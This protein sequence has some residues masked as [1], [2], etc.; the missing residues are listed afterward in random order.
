MPSL[1]RAIV[2]SA[3]A[4]VTL[5]L[6]AQVARAAA[7][8][9]QRVPQE[10]ALAREATGPAVVELRWSDVVRLS[11]RHPRLVA[12][13]L[14]TE[15]VR[16]GVAVAQSWPNPVLDA[17]LGRSVARPDGTAGAEWE[18]ALTLPLTPLV[19]RGARRGVALAESEV[20]TAEASVLRRELLGELRQS[21]LLLAHQQEQ[22]ATLE[23]L[24]EELASLAA[25]TQKKVDAG[26]S[27]P[28]EALR[29]ELA[30]QRLLV[31]L[32]GARAEQSR[33]GA[34]LASILGLRGGPELR[35]LFALEDLP[36]LPEPLARRSASDRMTPELRVGQA[37]ARVLLAEE[38]LARRARFPELSLTGFTGAEP[39]SRVFGA[40]VS[41]E[42]PLFDSRGNAL[43]QARARLAA[44]RAELAATAH[45]TSVQMAQA[46]ALCHQAIE[47]AGAY[48][49]RLVPRGTELAAVT[50]R[51]LELG[52]ASI[53][54]VIDARQSLLEVRRAELS[55][56]LE[57][58]LAC[59]AWRAMTR[60]DV[61]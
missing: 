35:V 7:E 8:Q 32:E 44:G 5:G 27:R 43:A 2:R 14:T 51:A 39:E 26:E 4:L 60:E 28:S 3:G 21:F 18:V 31:E 42:L 34:E 13:R 23:R 22:V 10:V 55:V 54:E 37:R 52:A 29:V 50:E 30:L 49:E 57:A 25:F 33:R 17:E 24:A 6:C 59:S 36:R 46:A 53:L 20:A 38:E 12:A 45:E 9:H 48:R 41:I 56:L 61:R 40:G 1:R 19:T 15:A 16:R 47:T 58:Q 11:E